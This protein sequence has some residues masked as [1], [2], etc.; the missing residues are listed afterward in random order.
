MRF[1]LIFMMFACPPAISKTLFIGDSLTGVISNEYIKLHPSERVD[2]DY[3]VGSGLEIKKTDWFQ[4]ILNKN[5]SQYSKIFISFGTNDFINVR[6]P[7]NSDWETNYI[8]K[9]GEFINIIRNKSNAL[10]L[11]IAPPVV[12]NSEIDWKISVV[13]NAILYSSRNSGFD[14]LD[15]RTLLGDDYQQFHNGVKI[16]TDDGIHYT[17]QGGLIIAKSI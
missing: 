11:W 2:V 1:I 15:V 12:N 9:S 8:I 17:N 10:V 16:R 7:K 13:R 5:L 14:C 3:I 4:R 6:T